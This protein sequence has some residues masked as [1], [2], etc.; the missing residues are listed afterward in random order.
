MEE[1]TAPG[2]SEAKVFPNLVFNL[3]TVKDILKRDENMMGKSAFPAG[4]ESCIVRILVFTADAQ[5]AR[6]VSDEGGND[7]T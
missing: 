1:R 7:R 5:I 4:P 3:M 6:A 2:L